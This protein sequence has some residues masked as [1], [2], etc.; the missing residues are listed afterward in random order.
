MPKL[1]ET[2]D[3]DGSVEVSSLMYHTTDEAGAMTQTFSSWHR[4]ANPFIKRR[5]KTHEIIWHDPNIHVVGTL[6]EISTKTLSSRR[7][8]FRLHRPDGAYV[9]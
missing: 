1:Q 7:T 4:L 3:S 5:R 6:L 9:R 8:V 2:V